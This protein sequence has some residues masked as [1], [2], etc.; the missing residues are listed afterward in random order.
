MTSASG[1]RSAHASHPEWSEAAAQ[2]VA[3][4]GTLDGTNQL[5]FLYVSDAFAAV[6]DEIATFLR[7]KTGVAH[8]IGT[9]GLGVCGTACEYFDTPA[10]SVLVAPFAESSF[11]IFGDARS[12]ALSGIGQEA[13]WPRERTPPLAVVHGD[14]TNEELP[15]L[16][17]ALSD[18]T[19]GFLVGGLSASRGSHAQLAGEVVDGGLS[20]VLIS[21]DAN[22]LITGL[23]QGCSPIGPSHVVTEAEHNV[24][25]TLDGKPALDLFRDDIGEELARDLQRCAGLIFVAL[26]VE[27]SD[28]GDYLVRNLI[29]IDPENGVIAIGEHVEAGQSVMFCRRDQ[30]SA[31]EDLRRMTRKL[32]QRAGGDIKGGLYFSCVARGPNQFGPDSREL[33]IVAEELGEFPLAGF[34]ANG[35]ISHNRLYGYTGVLTLFL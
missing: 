26:P 34:F 12:E 19:G 10:L 18:A 25:I 14:P 6:L 28:T 20:G 5:G 24:L 33:G 7:Q 11:R 27:G 8:W 15:Q 9:V 23:T 17:E 3:G 30:A 13:A 32:N 21:P 2:V 35:E 4:L 22:P 29:G 31:E 1:F 16:I